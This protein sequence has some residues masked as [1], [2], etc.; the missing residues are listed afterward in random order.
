MTL[1]RA[2]VEDWPADRKHPPLKQTTRSCF[3]AAAPPGRPSP[4]PPGARALCTDAPARFT[5]EVSA[6]VSRKQHAK[7][8]GEFFSVKQKL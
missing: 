1:V 5:S 2:G 4:A 6:P 3:P 8:F 7:A